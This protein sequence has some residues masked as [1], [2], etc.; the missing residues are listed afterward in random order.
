[1]TS[2]EF[3]SL[4]PDVRDAAVRGLRDPEDSGA[5]DSAEE[6]LADYESGIAARKALGRAA[7]MPV[8]IS[9]RAASAPGAQEHAALGPVPEDLI[10]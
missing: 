7:V 6:V 1:M 10:R 3:N 5:P 8:A 4:P 9:D 2:L